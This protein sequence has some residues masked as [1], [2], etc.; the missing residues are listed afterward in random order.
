MRLDVILGLITIGMTVLGGVVSVVSPNDPI[1]QATC[2]VSFFLLGCCAWV[3]VAKQSK[4][5]TESEAELQDQIKQLEQAASEATKLQALNNDLQQQMLELTRMN[6]TLA[7]E[8]ISTV[9]GGDSYCWMDIS[10]QFGRPTLTFIQSGKYTLYN[11]TARIV[12]VNRM[13]KQLERHQPIS[14]SDDIWLDLGEVQ[15]GRAFFRHDVLL[16]FSDEEAQSFNIF[17]GARNGMWTQELRLRKVAGQWSSA[18]R[19]WFSSIGGSTPPDK[20][21]FE[22]GREGFPRNEKGQVDWA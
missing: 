16:P 7:K 2:I 4:Q 10:F 17:F 9:T 14:L 22:Q 3:V 18:L 5:A 13:R 21:V 15:V 6:T 8:N 11:V 1:H 19:V 20:P 12:D